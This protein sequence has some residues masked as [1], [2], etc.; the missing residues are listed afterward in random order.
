[1]FGIKLTIQKKNVI[2]INN[3]ETLNDYHLLK[4]NDVL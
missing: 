2:K 1:V 4:L 3:E